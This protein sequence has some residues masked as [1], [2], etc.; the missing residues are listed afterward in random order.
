MRT[1]IF[2]TT[3]IACVL[4][5]ALPASCA[6]ANAA[7][8]RILN[9]CANSPDG[10]A[11]RGS[12]PAQQLRHALRNVPADQ[13]EYSGC[14]EM[15]NQA[16]LASANGG[17]SGNGTNG[18]GSG[19]GGGTGGGSATGG[20]GTTGSTGSAGAGSGAPLADTPP[21]PGAEQPVDVA[22]A[23]IAPGALPDIGKDSHRL[24]TALLALLALLGVAALTP[25]ALTIRRRV[26]DHR[27]A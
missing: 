20:F 2:L 15:I 23:A 16:L 17:G 5:L 13:L 10:A 11:L 22:G 14:Y 8:N 12:Y 6:W 19:T 27:R 24:P 21:P 3:L 1:P 18:E 25:A 26:V 9:D 7:D 4:L